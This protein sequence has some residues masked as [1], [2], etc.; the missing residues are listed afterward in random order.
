M[1]NV[2][3]I[4]IVDMAS[5]QSSRIASKRISDSVDN[6]RSMS[7]QPKK[8]KK[9]CAE[10]T[11]DWKLKMKTEDPDGFAAYQDRAKL[12]SKEYRQ[13][14]DTERRAD[15]N[16]KAA[17]RM[18][19]MR[20]RKALEGSEKPRQTRAAQDAQREV[21]RVQKQKQK[22]KEEETM[23]PQ[24][25]AKRKRQRN[26]RRRDAYHDKKLS[27]SNVP[28]LDE[29]TPVAGS[30]AESRTPAARR[31]ALSRAKSALPLSPRKYVQTIGDLVK[32]A[33]PRKRAIF[34]MQGQS[35]SVQQKIGHD[36]LSSLKQTQRSR[37]KASRQNRS[38]LL[39]VC[40]KYHSVRHSSRLYHIHRKTAAK[41]LFED[42]SSCSADERM[43]PQH[44]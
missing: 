23:T 27:S 5:R 6:P 13:N 40:G 15:S 8:R 41:R 4:V 10:A 12:Y 14:M 19:K 20:E 30:S 25:Q 43:E 3:G 33:T 24:Q 31:Q 34:E 7:P 22:Q 32:A 18:K 2:Y 16:K 44:K 36:V 38:A 26:N 9:S 39:S 1:H 28:R 42:V 29:N 35:S 11:K 21:W 37:D 17:S